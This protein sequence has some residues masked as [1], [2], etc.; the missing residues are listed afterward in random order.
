[1]SNP[2][3]LE[4]AIDEWEA[5]RKEHELVKQMLEETARQLDGANNRIALLAEQVAHERDEKERAQRRTVT[6]EAQLSAIAVTTRDVGVMLARIVGTTL[7]RVMDCGPAEADAIQQADGDGV[8]S[9][10]VDDIPLFLRTA[11]ALPG[12]RL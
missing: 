2:A 11:D 12:V 1:M 4:E 7:E 8:D 3:Q 6:L 10:P 9:D 5:E